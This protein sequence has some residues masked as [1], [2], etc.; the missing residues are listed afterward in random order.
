MRPTVVR[1]RR[2]GCRKDGEVR[3]RPGDGKLV[4]IVKVDIGVFV[5]RGGFYFPTVVRWRDA[6]AMMPGKQGRM[7]EA[8]AARVTGSG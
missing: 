3:R 5:D 1:R 6:A 2:T 8:G 4:Q 7:R